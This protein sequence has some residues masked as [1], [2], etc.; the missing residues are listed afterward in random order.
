MLNVKS[1]AARSSDAYFKLVQKFPLRTIRNDAE[2]AAASSIVDGLISK[3]KMSP[4]EA[5][6]VEVLEMLVSK[7]ENEHHRPAP[8]PDYELLNQLMQE[9]GLTQKA[10]ERA[11]G[12][13]HSTISD[14]LRGQRKLTRHHIGVL[15]SY[16]H[17]SPQTFSFE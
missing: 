7:Y 3:K 12:I 5:D 16:F 11:T 17:V 10:L 2:L 9:R 13:A 4:A 1:P 15:A 6:Y 14:I 8:L